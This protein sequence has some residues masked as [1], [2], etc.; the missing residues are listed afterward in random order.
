[1]GSL[2]D[3]H[4]VNDCPLWQI[5]RFVDHKVPCSYGCSQCVR[6]ADRIARRGRGSSAWTDQVS[7]T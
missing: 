4:Y 6:H 5:N 3:G 7:G 2:G 1:V